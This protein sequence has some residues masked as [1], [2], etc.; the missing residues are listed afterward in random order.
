MREP[1]CVANVLWCMLLFFDLRIFGIS[2]LDLELRLKLEFV[3]TDQRER[4]SVVE[5][6]ASDTKQ[7]RVHR[8][9]PRTAGSNSAVKKNRHVAPHHR[10]YKAVNVPCSTDILESKP[11][12]CRASRAPQRRLCVVAEVE[13]IEVR[14][15]PEEQR[16]CV[17]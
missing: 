4:S 6:P 3:T 7:P 16:G 10:E 8:G 15:Q 5:M 2:F 13:A 1:E 9:S 12:S 11:P 17:S 14:T